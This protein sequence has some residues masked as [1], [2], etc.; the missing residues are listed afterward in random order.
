ML[1]SVH[2]LIT[3]TE[4]PFRYLTAPHF[5]KNITEYTLKCNPCNRPKRTEGPNISL[6]I[7]DNKTVVNCYGHSGFGFVT[8]F[9]C[10]QEAISLLETKGCSV[11]QSVTVIGSGCMGLAMAIELARKGFTVNMVTKDTLDLTSW[12]AGGLFDPGTG[13]ENS[14]QGLR[15]VNLAMATFFV[16]QKALLG[17]HPY[18]NTEVVKQLPIYCPE[19]MKIGVEILAKEGHMPPC[20]PVSICFNNDIR[21][22]GYAE[23][24]TYFM[25]VGKIMSQLWQEVHRLH[26]PVT[27]KEID[28]I[29]TCHGDI[30]CNCAGINGAC[31]IGQEDIVPLRGHF[32]LFSP[33]VGDEHMNYMLFTKVEQDGKNEYIYLFPKSSVHSPKYPEGIACKGI[34]GGTFVPNT[35][36]INAEELQML[37]KNELEKL[38]IR[39]HQFFYGKQH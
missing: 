36:K 26:I 22:D 19:S 18:L 9:G 15:K 4:K 20:Q 39:A 10:V 38:A 31:L 29:A 13:T 2:L 35:E 34:L 6:D 16:Y 28:S 27:I 3:A 24:T 7:F 33:N 1:A 12:R 23:H 30:I 37:D 14:E 8:L 25:D 5:G 32:F 21:Y 17:E 11:K